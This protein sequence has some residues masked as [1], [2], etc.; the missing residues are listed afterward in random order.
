MHVDDEDLRCGRGRAHQGQ[1]LLRVTNG[2]NSPGLRASASVGS[3]I[4]TSRAGESVHGYNRRFDVP[5]TLS[6]SPPG[7][8]IRRADFRY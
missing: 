2:P 5:Q 3:R 1:S 4:L 7:A 6:A 8:E